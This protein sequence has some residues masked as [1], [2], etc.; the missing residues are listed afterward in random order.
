MFSF[1]FSKN[2]GSLILPILNT[3]SKPS[4]R[5]SVAWSWASVGT[6]WPIWG[7]PVNPRASRYHKC[8]QSRQSMLRAMRIWT[9]RLFKSTLN[10]TYIVSA[11]CHVLF[12]VAEN[13]ALEVALLPT[14]DPSTLCQV[15]YGPAPLLKSGWPPV[16]VIQKGKSS[17]Q[18]RLITSLC[19]WEK[20][21][22]KWSPTE[23]TTVYSM[24]C[25]CLQWERKAKHST[26]GASSLERKFNLEFSR[27]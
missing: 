26:M 2:T 14:S 11:N 4:V 25:K 22:V 8:N 16:S 20:N 12:E 17:K 6:T 27:F 15:S 7:A 24:M 5:L 18:L 9:S 1:F 19:A 10:V 3:K 13:L 21:G 23:V